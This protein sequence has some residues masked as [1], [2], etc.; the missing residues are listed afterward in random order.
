VKKKNVLSSIF[1]L[2]LAISSIPIIGASAAL[3]GTTNL[4]LVINAYSGALFITTPASATFTPITSPLG[5][6]TVTVTT[7][8]V[9]VTD[10]RRSTAGWITLAGA[11]DLS[12]GALAGETITANAI[13][14]EP[15]LFALVN[16]DGGGTAASPTVTN[17]STMA[18]AGTVIISGTVAANHTVTW[19]PKLT[20]S[21]PSQQKGGTYTGTITHSVS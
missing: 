14:Y 5:I 10:T 13:A 18:I 11:T 4:T 3:T 6:E 16:L 17:R 20:V 1:I 8:N 15:G 2:T 7:T 21:I 19:G 9:T 12:A